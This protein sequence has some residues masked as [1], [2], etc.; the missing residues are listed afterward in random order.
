MMLLASRLAGAQSIDSSWNVDV[1][2]G[3]T[4]S[5]PS[6]AFGSVPGIA[7]PGTLT[8]DPINGSSRI[9]AAIGADAPIARDLRLGVRAS[10]ATIEHRHAALERAPIAIEGGSLI[11]A[12]L[13]H[14]LQGVFRMIGLE[15]YVRYGV[16][17]WLSVSAGLP[18]MSL[19]TSKYTQVLRFVDPP[20]IRFVDGSIEQITA[21][22]D[23]PN[24]RAVIPMISV[25][26][27][28]M[29]PASTSGAI[30]LVPRVGFMRSLTSFTSD[31]AFN[32]QA[33]NASIGIRY[34][35]SPAPTQEQR[36]PEPA[37]PLTV[38]VVAEPIPL[39]M[40]VER[41]TFVELTRGITQETTSLVS[42]SIDTIE[43]RQGDVVTKLVRKRE[44]YRLAV[45]KPP[46]VLRA[47]LQLRFVDDAGVITS[48]ARLSA[49]RVESRRVLNF[50]P[51][52]V[53]DGDDETLPSRYLQL[54]VQEARSW[55]ESALASS[56]AHHW[57]YHV[58]NIIG[59]RMRRTRTFR[60]RFVGTSDGR[61][62][63]LV[64]RRLT[65][66]REYLA[67]R[68]GVASDRIET[69]IRTE[70]GG[71]A[72][73]IITIEQSPSELLGPAEFSQTYIETQLPRLQLIPD[74]ISEAGLRSWSIEARQGAIPVREFSD[75][76]ALPTALLWDMNEDIAADAA[77]KQPVVLVLRATDI[78]EQRTES[79]LVTVSLT[80]RLPLTAA[81][82]PI[83]KLEIFT[84]GRPAGTRQ[85]APE[86]RIDATSQRQLA[87]WTTAGLQLP[88]RQ[89]YE[90]AGMTLTVKLL[91]SR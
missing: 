54:S 62:R 17:E 18:I 16:T 70:A 24:V 14:D 25:S 68:F 12:T 47:S 78:D 65:V 2:L 46:S 36:V 42:T 11:N 7:S 61:R 37:E 63:D 30:T 49:V 74:V 1:G 91:E 75:S 27:E 90:Q 53:F 60:C 23:V 56:T 26:A 73:N 10:F 31:G 6:S 51:M 45:P 33:F 21:R 77:F 80:S 58:L 15:P 9:F 19:A 67:T 84:L 20:G 71:D 55:K 41:D 81:S 35:F 86:S 85:T 82:R 89:Y 57:Q 40:R 43:T 29:I 87:E 4:I 59:S 3:A 44:T 8:Y 22:G 32:S 34:R 79:E 38:P 13:R 72:G 69:E 64:E 28:A 66:I 83:K 52:M 88:E 50:L 76:V 48:N 39:A 5:A